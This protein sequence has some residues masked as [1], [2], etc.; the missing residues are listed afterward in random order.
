[1]ISWV[2]LILDC[3]SHFYGLYPV[4]LSLPT[5]TTTTTTTRGMHTLQKLGSSHY[6]VFALLTPLQFRVVIWSQQRLNSL[7]FLSLAGC[8]SPQAIFSASIQPYILS[9]PVACGVDYHSYTGNI[10]VAAWV[11]IWSRTK[12]MSV[13]LYTCA[14][15]HL[16]S[17]S[18]FILDPGPK[19]LT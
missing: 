11:N 18:F 15:N 17:W 14:M 8:A 16:P 13:Q 12:S 1:M 19:R 7:P 4:S 9:L 5:T 3:C 6:S 2:G 10:N